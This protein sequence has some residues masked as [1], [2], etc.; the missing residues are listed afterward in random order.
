MAAAWHAAGVRTGMKLRKARIQHLYF[1]VLQLCV[2]PQSAESLSSMLGIEIDG[3][4][5]VLSEL[6]DLGVLSSGGRAEA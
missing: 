1:R 2:Q 4:R 5:D 3:I 6:E